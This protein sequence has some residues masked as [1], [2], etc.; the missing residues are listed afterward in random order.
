MPPGGATRRMSVSSSR[1]VARRKLLEAAAALGYRLKVHADEFVGLGGTRLAVELGATSADHLVSTP[2]ADIDALG[3][4]DTVAVGLPDTVWFPETALRELPDDQLS[5][6]LFPVE[7]PE[8]FDAVAM[9]PDGQV[10]EIQVKSP[11]A[12]SHWMWGAFKMPARVFRDLDQLW[13]AREQ[14]PPSG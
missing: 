2:E 13:R 9:H 10:F 1:V 3:R 11:T 12:A 14:G 5:F 4:G 8:F 7:R 6:L